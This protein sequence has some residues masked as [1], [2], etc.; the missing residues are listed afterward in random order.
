M[1][2]QAFT[3]PELMAVYKI[4]RTKIYDEIAAGRLKT[5]KLGR[6]TRASAHAAAQWQRNL[7]AA[8]A[9]DHAG[10]GKTTEAA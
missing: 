10:V 6:A 7:E 1:Q 9:Q 4:G 2:P 5:Y 8:T 3:I